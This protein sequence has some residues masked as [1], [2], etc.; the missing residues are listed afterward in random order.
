MPPAG[1][2]RALVDGHQ[3]AALS[4]ALISRMLGSR[5]YNPPAPFSLLHIES[6]DSPV[7]APSTGPWIILVERGNLEVIG[8]TERGIFGKGDALF[9]SS[10]E[11]P[12]RL[13]SDGSVW[14]AMP[15]SDL[16]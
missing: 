4:A 16:P 10:E 13:N 1:F 11:A 12:L 9:A 7:Q 5:L 6:A 15:D 14:I 2:S 3:P 8:T